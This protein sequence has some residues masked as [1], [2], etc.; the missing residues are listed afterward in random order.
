MLNRI[1]K[2]SSC[3]S[4]DVECE[5][6]GSVAVI[7]SCDETPEER[8]AKNYRIFKQVLFIVSNQENTLV[9]PL[10]CQ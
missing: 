6:Y 4:V 9:C 1:L 10:L 3:C 5:L 7:V 2:L 8:K